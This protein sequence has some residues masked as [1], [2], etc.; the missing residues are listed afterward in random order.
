MICLTFKWHGREKLSRQTCRLSSCREFCLKQQ[1]NQFHRQSVKSIRY[2][3]G[4]VGGES[5]TSNARVQIWM[6]QSSVHEEGKFGGLKRNNRGSV[7]R[8]VLYWDEV[9]CTM[10]SKS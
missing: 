6:D 4:F 7:A 8:I 1:A 9:I 5:I 3:K 10:F 2:K